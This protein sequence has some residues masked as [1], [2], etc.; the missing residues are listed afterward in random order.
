MNLFDSRYRILWIDAVRGLVIIFMVFG[1]NIQFGS[2]TE[3]L[4]NG[5]YFENTA[6]RF[7]YSFHMP[8]LMLISGFLFRWTVERADFWENRVRKI[9]GPAVLGALIPASVFFFGAVLNHIVNAETLVS[10]GRII[11]TYY[12]FLWAIFFASTIVW[13]VYKVCRNSIFLLFVVGIVLLFIPDYLNIALWKFM[14]PYFAVGYIWNLKGIRLTWAKRYKWLTAGILILLFLALFIFYD[15]DSFIYTTGIMVDS[16]S[17][18][19]ID[20]YRYAIGFAG[21][22]MVIWIVYIIYPLI[23]KKFV[24]LIHIGR[25]SLTVY[26]IDI[27]LNGYILPR[28]TGY[29]SLN[30][31]MTAIETVVVTLL[32]LGIDSLL[33]KVPRAKNVSA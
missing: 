22:A 11:V 27:L 29:F 15:N 10:C 16:I 14:Y 18:L 1:H 32:C 4:N 28:L 31:L 8:C 24:W 20:L 30:Y 23:N 5:L 21:S 7:I 2:G 6:F 33:K 26:M 9:L 12:W 25:I 17:Q 3:M 13:I 19:C